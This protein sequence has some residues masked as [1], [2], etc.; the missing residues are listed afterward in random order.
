MTW[1]KLPAIHNKEKQDFANPQSD[2]IEGTAK[3]TSNILQPPTQILQ[4][5]GTSQKI[6]R[7]K[8]PFDSETSEM[9]EILT[10]IKTIKQE[11]VTCKT[12]MDKVILILTRLGHYV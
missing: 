5:P 4:A 2:A 10:T 12:F 9:L 11:F 6:P 8:A 1:P 3:S 7:D